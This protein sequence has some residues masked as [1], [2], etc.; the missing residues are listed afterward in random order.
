MKQKVSSGI[1]KIGWGIS[2]LG[3]GAITMIGLLQRWSAI[4]GYGIAIGMSAMLIGGCFIWLGSMRAGAAFVFMI[5]PCLIGGAGT[6]LWSVTSNYLFM[7]EAPKEAVGRVM[8]IVQSMSSIV[9]VIAP[10]LGGGLVT[11]VG[12]SLAFKLCGIMLALLG[13]GAMVL[14]RQLWPQREQEVTQ[15]INVS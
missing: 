3:L 14:Q 6:G 7:N 4:T 2:L 15:D 10:L 13:I 9:W 5:L 8:G 12:P 1:F 11:L